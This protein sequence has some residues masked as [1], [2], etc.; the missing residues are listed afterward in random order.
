MSGESECSTGSPMRAAS[1]VRASILGSIAGAKADFV[2]SRRECMWRDKT[3][4]SPPQIRRMR[5]PGSRFSMSPGVP[6]V[7]ERH[8]FRNPG[9]MDIRL[10]R[11]PDKPSSRTHGHRTSRMRG[12]L[13]QDA[14]TPDVQD[15]RTSFIQDAWTPDV[16][17]RWISRMDRS[18]H[19]HEGPRL[20]NRGG[21]EAQE[22]GAGAE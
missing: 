16:H 7:V 10:S 17:D 6:V 19:Y 4:G 9:E 5:L 1:P 18:G 21:L 3:N 20:G 14:W 11:Q 12:H 2:G 13:I 15:T 22:I 8:F